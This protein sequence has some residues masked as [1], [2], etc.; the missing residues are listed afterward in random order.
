MILS[1]KSSDSFL[2]NLN[3]PS[4][5]LLSSENIQENNGI[6]L[7]ENSLEGLTKA[8]IFGQFLCLN[9]KNCLF[10]K[11]I[12]SVTLVS[13]LILSVCINLKPFIDV[14]QLLWIFLIL[15]AYLLVW[16]YISNECSGNINYF[17]IKKTLNADS[18]IS[19]K[20]VK[21]VAFFVLISIVATFMTEFVLNPK[22]T[23][24]IMGIVVIWTC[25]RNRNIN[26]KQIVL[27]SFSCVLIGYFT[28]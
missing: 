8:L 2:F 28:L 17:N 22:V 25:Y 15:E 7:K 27:L 23:A 13:R 6:I 24:V 21:K 19:V 1:I 12:I 18:L 20:E 9:L 14:F 16:V 5:I 11:I 26:K 3:D 4:I 10:S